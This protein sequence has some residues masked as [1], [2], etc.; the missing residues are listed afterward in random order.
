VLTKLCLS[1]GLVAREREPEHDSST[2][3]LARGARAK[4]NERKTKTAGAN[5]SRFK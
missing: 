1:A 4:R 5:S 3:H 2:I